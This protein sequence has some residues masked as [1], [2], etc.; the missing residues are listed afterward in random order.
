MRKEFF[1]AHFHPERH[2]LRE[3]FTSSLNY[4]L[5]ALFFSA[6]PMSCATIQEIAGPAVRS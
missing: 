4:Y 1:D 6:F 2:G 5:S 3:R